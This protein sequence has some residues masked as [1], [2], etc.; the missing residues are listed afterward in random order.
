MIPLSV[1]QRSITMDRA[2]DGTLTQADGIDRSM[3]REMIDGA[4]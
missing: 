2:A 3:T 4:A 1:T